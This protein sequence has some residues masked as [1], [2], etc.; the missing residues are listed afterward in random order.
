MKGKR[1]LVILLALI[2]ALTSFTA[3]GWFG[4]GKDKDK[5]KDKETDKDRRR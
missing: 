4:K 5:D 3:C 2:L 1:L